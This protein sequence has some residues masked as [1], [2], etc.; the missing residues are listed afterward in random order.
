MAKEMWIVFVIV[1]VSATAM[2]T[3]DEERPRLDVN[4]VLNRT[5][6][7]ITIR[8]DEDEDRVPRRIK[9]MEC[10]ENSNQWCAQRNVPPNECCQHR[11]DG[12]IMKCV[13]IQDL[14]QV[15]YKTRKESQSMRVSV[16]CMCM[17][18]EVDGVG[19]SAP[20]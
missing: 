10:A 16:G 2:P 13:E 9:V 1:F 5:V 17:M 4:D 7:P 12:V 11:H 8:I 14:V 18:Q 15:F 19:D 3:R 20:S 6:C